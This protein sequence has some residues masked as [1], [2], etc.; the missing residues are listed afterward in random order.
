VL[1]QIP[2]E[3]FNIVVGKSMSQLADTAVHDYMLVDLDVTH[4]LI[5]IF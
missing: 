3:R 4:R 1:G 2:S 5:L